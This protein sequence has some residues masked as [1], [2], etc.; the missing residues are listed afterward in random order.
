MRMR[1]SKIMT[2]IGF[3]LVLCLSGCLT[4]E[5]GHP[6]RVPVPPTS[7]FFEASRNFCSERMPDR[8]LVGY[9]GEALLDT[10]VYFFVISH[11]GDT[12]YRDHWPALAHL[13]D[14]AGNAMTDS[15]KVVFIQSRM[16]KLVDGPDS[17]DPLPDSLV[18]AHDL[19]GTFHYQVGSH[20]DRTIAWSKSGKK[21]V[22]L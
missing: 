11:K 13:E 18:S 19:G 17:A 1:L 4:P 14:G 21:V 10:S 7:M 15:A 12:I 20:H 22:E 8:F 2:S 16:R 9:Y 6:E 3:G 5:S